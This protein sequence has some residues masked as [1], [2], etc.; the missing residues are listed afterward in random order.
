MVKT[1]ILFIHPSSNAY[2]VLGII[3]TVSDL[4]YSNEKDR[5][6]LHLH[7]YT[8]THRDTLTR[9]TYFR[10]CSLRGM[11]HVDGSVLCR[12]RA[13]L[14]SAAWSPAMHD[15]DSIAVDLSSL[16]QLTGRLTVGIYQ[17]LL[18]FK[19]LPTRH[20]AEPDI[21]QESGICKRGSLCGGLSGCFFFFPQSLLDG[22]EWSRSL[23]DM[24][25]SEDKNWRDWFY[26]MAH[27]SFLSLIRVF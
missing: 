12:S 15:Y 11:Q 4:W 18:P 1:L 25:D 5:F 3:L 14:H 24:I 21:T 9:P 19:K 16:K 23:V 6:L 22:R 8:C 2:C 17:G 7:M 26:F 13:H 10:A 27:L 20:Q